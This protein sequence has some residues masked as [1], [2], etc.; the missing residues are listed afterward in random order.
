MPPRARQRGLVG[1]NRQRS[2][3]SERIEPIGVHG[4]VLRS[5]LR[6]A[7]DAR[8]QDGVESPSSIVLLLRPSLHPAGRTGD[9]A[10]AV[11]AT[12]MSGQRRQCCGNSAASRATVAYYRRP[13]V[14]ALVHCCNGEHRTPARARYG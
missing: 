8:R 10:L 1:E 11:K 6:A 14:M 9:A 7:V 5:R 13:R 4:V 2:G 3:A 12:A